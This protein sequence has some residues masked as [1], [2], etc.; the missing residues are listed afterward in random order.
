MAVI[1]HV[2]VPDRLRATKKHLPGAVKRTARSALRSYAVAS[3]EQ[4][5]LPD[6]LIIGTKRGGTTS[7]WNWLVRH[8][9]VAPM[10][11]AAQQ[12]KS[13]HYFDINFS[14]GLGWYRSH[15][16]TRRALAGARRRLGGP[17]LTGE[18]S[19]YYRASVMRRG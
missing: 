18:A 12:I 2:E 19:P 5:A 15:F 17:V 6:F 11:P 8:P 3:A 7:L 4:R 16:P 1:H 9:Q 14:R 10:F 13:P